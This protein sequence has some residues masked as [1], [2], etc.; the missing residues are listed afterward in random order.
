MNPDFFKKNWLLLLPLLLSLILNAYLLV[1]IGNRFQ[2]TVALKPK[3]VAQAMVLLPVNTPPPE[4]PSE[5]PPASQV[6]THFA[7]KAAKD[8]GSNPEEKTSGGKNPVSQAEPAKGPV[9][10]EFSDNYSSP[11]SLSHYVW[12]N[13]NFSPSGAGAQDCSVVNGE[14]EQTAPPGGRASVYAVVD[15]SHFDWSLSDYTVEADFKLDHWTGHS[16]AFG[17][18][19]RSPSRGNNYIFKWNGDPEE[20]EPRWQVEKRTGPNCCS[21]HFLPGSGWN[22]GITKPV[23]TPGHWMHLKV[24]AQGNHFDCYVNL[25]DGKGEQRVISVSDP[26][27]PF[28]SGG[29]GIRTLWLNDPNTLHIRNYHAAALNA[30]PDPEAPDE[31][32]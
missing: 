17:L 27:S 22:I 24:V 2:I 16:G 3:A 11:D 18:I 9:A 26:Q 30:T 10:N 23:Y 28:A 1:F 6:K 31:G 5:P 14:W 19:F 7:V 21:Y 4:A 25:N 8:S 20:T 15:R 32:S 12:T 13:E 29:V